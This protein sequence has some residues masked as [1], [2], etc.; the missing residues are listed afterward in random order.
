MAIEYV[1]LSGELLL[2]LTVPV[3]ASKPETGSM[4]L[5]FSKVMSLIRVEVDPVTVKL[6]ELLPVPPR[7]VVTLTG[8]LV[9]PAGTLTVI[10]VS[11]F[12]VIDEVLVVLKV[13]DVAPVKLLPVMVTAVPAAPLVGEKLE[14]TGGKGAEVVMVKL[15]GLVAVPP[16]VVAVTVPVFAPLGTVAVI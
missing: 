5:P 8:P 1:P 13:T 11:L 4:M 9:A 12:T 7:A 16:G 6:A 2:M 15:D 14:T 3:V 10:C